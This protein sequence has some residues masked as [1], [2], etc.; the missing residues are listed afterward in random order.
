[1]KE[2]KKIIA[3]LSVFGYDK[4]YDAV[5]CALRRI[6]RL[7]GRHIS[8]QAAGKGMVI[9]ESQKKDGRYGGRVP[10]ADNY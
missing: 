4:D 8:L 9:Y 10:S 3:F 5:H 2:F 6:E 7:C 1:M